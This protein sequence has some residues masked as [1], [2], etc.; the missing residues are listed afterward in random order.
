MHII[1]CIVHIQT[2]P[3]IFM[4]PSMHESTQKYAPVLL[5]GNPLQAI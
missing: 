1:T 5:T 2:N 4:G 3:L